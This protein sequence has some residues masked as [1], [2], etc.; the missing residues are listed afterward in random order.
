MEI[1]STRIFH[2]NAFTGEGCQGNPA[3]VCLLPSESEEAFYR[4]VA[5]IMG[6]S[7]TAFVYKE[8]EDYR[9]RWFSPN[10]TEVDLC[11]HAT[12]ASASILFGK[13]YASADLPVHFKTRSGVLTTKAKGESIEMDFP[14]EEIYGLDGDAYHL[15]EMLGE[16]SIYTGRTRFDAF[17]ELDSEEKVRR[18]APDFD[19]LKRLPGRGVIVTARS[20]D[21]K[22]DFVSRFFAPK[23]AIDEDPVTGSAHCA[24][25]PYWG[26]LLG[27]DELTGYQASPQ[28]GVVRV[29]VLGK[30]VRLSGKTKEYP[31]PERI[32]KAIKL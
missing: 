12:L 28:G 30:R 13:G 16:K 23:L 21:T 24:L 25:G 14:A 22:Y 10:G 4:K 8:G 9:L 2:V 32:I 29:K 3:G 5:G 11:G 17:A 1:K 20:A 15:D 7:E 6:F 27:K 31:V 18:L 19:A 26:Y